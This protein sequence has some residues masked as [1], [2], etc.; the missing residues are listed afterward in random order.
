MAL[1]ENLRHLRELKG[2]TLEEI[3]ESVDVTKQAMNKYEQGKM[4][5]NGI[6]LVDIAEKL[7]VTVEKLVRGKTND[8]EN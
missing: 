5:P 6:V 2:L 1:A 4:I 3:A 8:F 7:G